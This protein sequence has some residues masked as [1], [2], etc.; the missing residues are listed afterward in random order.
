MLRRPCCFPWADHRKPF[1]DYLPTFPMTNGTN[2]STPVCEMPAAFSTP[3]N[4]TLG[5]YTRWHGSLDD[6]NAQSRKRTMWADMPLSQAVE[7]RKGWSIAPVS[8]VILMVAWLVSKIAIF[9]KA[10]S[11]VK[12]EMTSPNTAHLLPAAHWATS[13][14]FFSGVCL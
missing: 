10:A 13:F 14:F 5:T 8:G 9:L 12:L 11:L 1:V 6:W 3:A 4:R 2:T 7:A